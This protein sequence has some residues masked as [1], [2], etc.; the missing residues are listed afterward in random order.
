M[1]NY[2][3]PFFS[4]CISGQINAKHGEAYSGLFILFPFKFGLVFVNI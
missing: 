4:T 3:S 2:G 1:L